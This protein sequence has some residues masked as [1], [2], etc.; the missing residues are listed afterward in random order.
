ML[1]QGD[2]IY[3][4]PSDLFLERLSEFKRVLFNDK[5][6]LETYNFIKENLNTNN[7][8]YSKQSNK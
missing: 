5:I 2:Y 6:I 3:D 4:N 8:E 7:F 1:T